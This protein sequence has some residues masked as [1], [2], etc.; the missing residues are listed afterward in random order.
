MPTLA[1]FYD[2]DS[3][4]AQ[5]PPPAS[6]TDPMLAVRKAESVGADR[7]PG[8]SEFAD[9]LDAKWGGLRDAMGNWIGDQLAPRT[10]EQPV[11]RRSR[12]GTLYPSAEGAG[13]FEPLKGFASGATQALGTLVPRTTGEAALMFAAPPGL[14]GIAGPLEEMGPGRAA[15]ELATLY[16]TPS[17][18][19]R[20]AGA[21]E[22]PVGK[23]AAT[24]LSVAAPAASA[25]ID[26]SDPDDPY[27]S[28]KQYGK[29]A[30]D[31]LG[32]V[33]MAAAL[34]S[35]VKG[36]T[37]EALPLE[38]N[39]AAR[40][41]ALVA[42]GEKKDVIKHEL[43]AMGVPQERYN[44]VRADAEA[45]LQQHYASAGAKGLTK[46]RELFQM[47]RSGKGYADWYGTGA[48]LRQF[49]GK[50]AE[51]FAKMLAATSNNADVTGNVA[52]ALKAYGQWKIDPT[53][54]PIGLMATIVPAVKKAGAN[55]A[56]EGRKVNNFVR[57]LLGDPEA[58]VVDRHMMRVFGFPGDVP[59]A[60]QYDFIEHA[61]REMAKKEGIKPVEAQAALWYA[62]KEKQG[63]RLP[64]TYIEELQKR[65]TGGESGYNPRQMFTAP[66]D[67]PQDSEVLRRLRAQY[68]ESPTQANPR[69]GQ[70]KI[71]KTTGR[72][73]VDPNS[74]RPVMEPA[75]IP[76]WSRYAREE[77]ET[78]D[79]YWQRQ[80]MLDRAARLGRTRP[81]VLG[82]IR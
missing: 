49:F 37:T 39:A 33:S 41:A 65:E 29:L 1:S 55:T 11:L 32:G 13:G 75:R 60:T 8:Q 26:T 35:G 64:G 61:I 38:K 43:L 14:T 42:L 6:P 79:Q 27:A 10:P 56:L 73:I 3:P 68:K 28:L 17:R 25:A 30:F 15:Q 7:L 12:T 46:T 69:Y 16:K 22:T 40:G 24:A 18:A 44:A 78:F 76:R 70:Q 20:V 67:A 72:P 34:R 36:H 53:K 48:E 23:G 47:L 9:W 52:L 66:P 54:D 50:D 31:L 62:V 57:A 77:G 81:S 80:Q 21:L 45:I 63:Q 82:S 58:I 5:A 51:V 74:G 19:A 71:S 59:T 4:E 2:D